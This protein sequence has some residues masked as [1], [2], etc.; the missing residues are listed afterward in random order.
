MTQF[1][2]LKKKDE[3][4][5]IVFS[6]TSKIQR[7]FYESLSLLEAQRK[8]DFWEGQMELYRDSIYMFF[9]LGFPQ[10]PGIFC[11]RNNQLPK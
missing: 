11:D 5:K 4:I 9:P 3:V 6:F 2:C 1:F 8:I 10:S 7:Q